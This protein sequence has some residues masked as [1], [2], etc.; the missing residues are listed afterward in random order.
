MN[1]TPSDAISK[2]DLLDLL[3][4]LNAAADQSLAEQSSSSTHAALIANGKLTITRKLLAVL[5]G[6]G[7]AEYRQDSRFTDSD[8][9]SVEQRLANLRYTEGA[10]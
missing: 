6:T 5:T 8:L 3:F 9:I 7:F 1:A 10:A 2:D 4:A